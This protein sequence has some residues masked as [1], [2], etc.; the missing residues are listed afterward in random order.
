M[1]I[2]FCFYFPKSGNDPFQ[3][4]PMSIDSMHSTL[5]TLSP[6]SWLC[7]FGLKCKRVKLEKI[8]PSAS[9]SVTRAST[10]Q[11]QSIPFHKILLSLLYQDIPLHQLFSLILTLMGKEV[12]K[13]CPFLTLRLAQFFSFST[14]LPA[15]SI[16]I[17]QRGA[18]ASWSTAYYHTIG[19]SWFVCNSFMVDLGITRDFC[20]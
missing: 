5:P 8:I 13:T 9:F 15:Q 12:R 17:S 7:L 18:I 19:L 16:Q 10:K 2:R 14:L 6:K 3:L 11:I 20:P 1:K 4:S